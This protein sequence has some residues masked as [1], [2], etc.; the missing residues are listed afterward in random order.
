VLF[1]STRNPNH[2]P[3]PSSLK[4]DGRDRYDRGLLKRDWTQLQTEQLMH[5]VMW[6]CLLQDAYQEQ[7]SLTHSVASFYFTGLILILRNICAV[8][9]K[10]NLIKSRVMVR[11]GLG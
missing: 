2:T 7:D 8:I 4:C 9:F 5:G 3:N 6:V 10:F 11:L 1:S